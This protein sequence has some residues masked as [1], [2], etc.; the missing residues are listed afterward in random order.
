MDILDYLQGRADR[1]NR[2]IDKLIPEN[3]EP[4]KLAEAYRH[5]ILAGGKRLRPVLTLTAA[6]AV[7]GDPDK[8]IES[9]AAIEVLHTFTLIHDDMMDRDGFRRGTET[10]HKVWNE[11]LALIAGDALFAKVFEALTSNARSENLSSEKTLQLFDTVSKASFRIC[12][13][14]ASDMDF[15]DRDFVKESEY[16]KMVERKTG[17]LIEAS[18]RIGALIGGGSDKEIEA[19]TEYGLLLGV[20]FQIHD[21]VLGVAGEQNKVGK[22][23]GSDIRKGKWTF[24]TVISYREASDKDKETLLNI[25]GKEDATDDEIEKVVSIFKKTKALEFSS[26]KAKEVVEK[27]KNELEIPPNSE[28]R[29]FLLEIADFS[30]E[31]EL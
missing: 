28:A 6:E 21:D 3:T 14:Q 10:V 23:I 5:L 11:P 26:K 25:L 9:A 1:V 24:P 20:A 13:G 16:I 22:P 19:L 4:P 27:A 17:A 31:R 8:V 30:I 12:Q 29:D 7:G 15:E 18:T 2:E